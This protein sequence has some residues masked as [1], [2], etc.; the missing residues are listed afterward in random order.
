MTKLRNALLLIA[1]AAPLLGAQTTTP[2]NE[3]SVPSG[4]ADNGIH[5]ATM[6]MRGV[7]PRAVALGE[8]MGGLTI[9]R[10]DTAR[11]RLDRLTAGFS[12]EAR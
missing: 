12:W 7:T 5:A 4:D 2:K 1:V 11:T 3:G 9:M 8:A 10:L 6:L